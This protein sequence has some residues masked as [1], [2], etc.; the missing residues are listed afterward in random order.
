LLTTITP[1][2]KYQDFINKMLTIFTIPKS[3][4]DPHINIIQ[5]NAIQSW[6]KL[7]PKCEIILFGND[8]GVAEAANE[9]NVQHIPQI[10][11]N[12]FGTPLLNSAFKE[13]QKL[14]KNDI[15]GYI[16][17]DIILM[18]DF[19]PAVQK[20]G[21]SLF[22][23][24][25]RRW[26]LDIKEEVNFRDSNWEKK[27]REHISKKGE[28]HGFSGIDY[29]VFPRNLPHNLPSFAVGRP[30]WD[31]WLIYHIRCLKIPVIDATE[32]ITAVHQNHVYSHSPWGK[33][34][35]VEG[36]E[37]ERN[38]KL[39]GGYSNLLTLREA[40][41]LLTSQDLKRPTYPRQIFSKLSLFYPWR[42]ILALKRKLTW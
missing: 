19:I 31:N 36:P 13:A 14:T 20:I 12:E 42:L 2:G 35:R 22:L 26:D 21:K 1:E 23:M 6:L 10:E 24:S 17:T 34:T 11:K 9:F 29:F 40:D 38:L 3:F 30:G 33:R 18:S 32:V 41:W 39:A 25:G 37:M 7:S 15:L 28:L 4:E 5:R 27:L 16:N 8:E